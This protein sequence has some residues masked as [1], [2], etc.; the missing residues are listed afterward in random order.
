MKKK[1]ILFVG[2]HPYGTSGN[3]HML[4]AILQQVN[5]K[6]HDFSVFAV[7]N[8][9]IP[10]LGK[11]PCQIIEGGL[12]RNDIFGAKLLL[13]VL[14]ENDVDVLFFVGLDLWAFFGVHN[15]LIE[16]KNKKRFIWCSLFPYDS[17]FIRKDWLHFVNAIDIPCVYS[18]FGYNLIKTVSERVHYFRPPLF[19][20][21]KFVPYTLE[22]KREL[23]K[24]ILHINDDKFLFGFFGKNQFRKD[25]LRLIH[26]FYE[27]KK[28]FSNIG[29]YLHTE[30]PGVFN[31]D[32]YIND[33]GGKPGDVYVKKQNHAYSTDGLVKS[34]NM[35][36]CYV[37]ISL[38]E[39]LSWTVLEAM[40]CGVPCL[41][42]DS[43]AHK[44]LAEGDAAVKVP[45]TEL[46]FLPVSGASG[47]TFAETRACHVPSLIY[48]MKRMIASEELRKQTIHNGFIR[49]KEWL[50][51][52]SNVND[53]LASAYD[54]HSKPI[55]IIESKKINKV[56]FMQHSSAGDIFMTTRCLK[57]I[58][59]RHKGVPIVYMTQK[60]Y[61]DILVNNPYIDE[62]VDWDETKRGDYKYAYNPHGDKILPGHW[63]RNSNSILSDFYH[64]VL[65]VEPDDF[66]IDKK[67]I[68]FPFPKSIPVMI[69]HTTGGDP[70]F[71]TYKYGKDIC[72]YFRGK[73]FTIQVGS[74]NDFP[75]GADY[76]LRGKLSFR[77]TAYVVSKAKVAFT[78]DSF[79]SH[80][81]GALGV[82][83]VCLFGS[84][85]KNVVKPNQ[86][87]GRL[88]CMEPDYIRQ[89]PW[90]G[91]CSASVRDCP[92][93]CTG[94][95]DP[96]DIIKAI[97][98]IER[99]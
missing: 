89:C 53:V 45:S 20:A 64:K 40:L 56:L 80:L 59:E 76:D 2:E 27:V 65:M 72:D 7:T 67:A 87:N 47:A 49:A 11:Y 23:R 77:E 66:F 21:E 10:V 28:E 62:I 84:G 95:H 26:A 63:G 25:P 46:A 90:L 85:N 68:D 71:R 97:E 13:E 73:Y 12:D 75:A 9:G 8:A 22:T 18:E 83:Q 39:G 70:Q 19:D 5:P 54:L 92:T 16:L 79:I 6:I 61:Q 44:E 96:K 78:V 98:E 99:S 91:P 1:K 88:I 52:V 43:T 60:K 34:Y 31:L 50:D 81:C 24:K 4:N 69:A 58:K 48:L 17:P 37:N 3:S 93:P 32:R 51:N 55:T 82:S 41:L 74:A 42:S 57:G 36:D 14:Q 30:M 33:C 29:L 15:Q 86:M 35:V 38:Q 94:I